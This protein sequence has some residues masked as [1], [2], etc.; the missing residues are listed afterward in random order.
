MKP[1]S[2]LLADFIFLPPPLM[3]CATMHELYCNLEGYVFFFFLIFSAVAA[4]KAGCYFEGECGFLLLQYPLPKKRTFS[5]Y[6]F[7]SFLSFHHYLRLSANSISESPNASAWNLPPVLLFLVS[8]HF[9]V[10]SISKVFGWILDHRQE[11]LKSP[12]IRL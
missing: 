9:E 12:T 8:Q 10:P 5:F 4:I 7:I 1:S 11:E 6:D 3:K 2:K